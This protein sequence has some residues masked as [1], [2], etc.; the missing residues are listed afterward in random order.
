MSP[1]DHDP[2]GPSPRRSPEP[3]APES[4]DAATI[5]RRAGWWAAEH[6]GLVISSLTLAFAG[7]NILAFGNFDAEVAQT[8][9]QEQGLAS[10][11]IG[12]LF[13]VASTM[14]PAVLMVGLALP[15]IRRA[16]GFRWIV[17][18]TAWGV[19]AIA[20][21]CTLALARSTAL[22]VVLMPLVVLLGAWRGKR[23]WTLRE[24]PSA[25]APLGDSGQGA[26]I[27]GREPLPPQLQTLLALTILTTVF[28]MLD[29]DPWLPRERV[30]VQGHRPITGY[31]LNSAG[32]STVVVR[33]ESR[34]VVR[35]ATSA[36]LSRSLCD[37]PGARN[38]WS[39]PIVKVGPRPSY[40]PCPRE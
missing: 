23:R 13:E 31:V 32:S 28:T 18:G 38:W 30:D 6:P 15:A 9:L 10:V 36:I 3:R 39:E 35:V 12:Q 11:A 14:V 17:P 5:A 21:F 7:F 16:D 40:S 33:A 22:V 2:Q 34:E 37:W 1:D 26:D 27:G 20:A 25:D 19:A 29:S 24:I 4:L 8:V